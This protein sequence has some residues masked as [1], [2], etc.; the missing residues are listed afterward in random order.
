LRA[1]PLIFLFSDLPHDEVMQT[2]GTFQRFLE[3]SV[4]SPIQP[5]TAPQP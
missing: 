4:L 3:T 5:E 2:R 1:N